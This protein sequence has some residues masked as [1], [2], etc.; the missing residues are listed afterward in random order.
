MLVNEDMG[1]GMDMAYTLLSHLYEE[2]DDKITR[3]MNAI[4]I[5]RIRIHIGT[6]IRLFTR[7]DAPQGN[8]V[9]GCESLLTQGLML[10]PWR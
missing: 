6:L 1:I 10:D 5:R 3:V 4:E 9:G 7:Y 8:D 2:G